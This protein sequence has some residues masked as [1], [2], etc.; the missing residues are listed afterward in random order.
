[1]YARWMEPGVTLVT[2][3]HKLTSVH[4]RAFAIKYFGFVEDFNFAVLIHEEK[5]ATWV[6]IVQRYPSDDLFYHVKGQ[7]GVP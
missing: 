2:A 7:F 5:L 1:M 6:N 4:C 3:N